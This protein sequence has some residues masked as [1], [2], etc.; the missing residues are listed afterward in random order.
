LTLE[1]T[2]WTLNKRKAKL[3]EDEVRERYSQ[4]ELNRMGEKSPLF[5]YTL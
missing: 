4:V 2:L 3:S 1:F 5:R